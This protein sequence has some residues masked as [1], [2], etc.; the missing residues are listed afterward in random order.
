MKFNLIILLLIVVTPCQS[1]K[2]RQMSLPFN[3]SVI[4]TN[5][6]LKNKNGIWLWKGIKYNGYIIEKFQEKIIAKLPI[7]GGQEN[8]I[9]LGWYK[10]GQKRYQRA[11]LNGNREGKDLSWYET[12]HKSAEFFFVNDKYEGEQLT[13]FD[14]GKIWQSLH[15]K[16]GYEEGKQK[17]WNESGRVVNNFTV[18][19]GKLY[20]VV[21]RYDCISVINK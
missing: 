16:N 9:A 19:N 13:Y 8:G 10:N 15:Y 20:G 2:N 6:D 4:S 18:K 1:N 17:S 12:G 14:N 7:I 21:G 5:A 3:Q 11:Y